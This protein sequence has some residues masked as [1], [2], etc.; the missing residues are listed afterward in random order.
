MRD[1]TSKT[2]KKGRIHPE[3]FD[4]KLHQI[5]TIILKWKSQSLSCKR[6]HLYTF[7]GNGVGGGE[8]E[9]FADV[10]MGWALAAEAACAGALGGF[11]DAGCKKSGEN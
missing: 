9:L 4:K 3:I 8:V 7:V 5:S 1:G 10:H 2:Q 6:Q 11:K